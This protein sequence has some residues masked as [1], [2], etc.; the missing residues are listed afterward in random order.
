MALIRKSNVEFGVLG[1]RLD[2]PIYD[3]DRLPAGSRIHGPAL[4]QEYASTTVVAPG[5]RLIVDRFGN[6]DIEVDVA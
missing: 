5:D 2:T 6:L 3:R 1:G 4:V